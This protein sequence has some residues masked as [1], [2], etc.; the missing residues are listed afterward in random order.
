[1]AHLLKLNSLKQMEIPRYGGEFFCIPEGK[2]ETERL[3]LRSWQDSDA[4]RLFEIA[5]DPRIGPKCGWAPHQTID[6]SRRTISG[7]FSA[8][9]NYAV[10]YKETNEICACISLKPANPICLNVEP[11]SMEMGFW[12]AVEYWGRGIIPEAAKRLL[13]HA[14]EE[15]KLKRVWCGYYD[16]NEPSRRAQEKIGFIPHHSEGKVPDAR[17]EYHDCYYGYI[18]SGKFRD[19]L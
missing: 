5:R 19:Q 12:T 16:G 10:I 1:M 6:D 17:G 14:F 8:P 2:M 15:L 9:E 18:I 7:I 13:H 11:I 4:E 3:I